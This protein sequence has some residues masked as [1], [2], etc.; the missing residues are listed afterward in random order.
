M[1]IVFSDA[2]G[3]TWFVTDGLHRRPL[4]AGEPQLLVDLGLL[5]PQRDAWGNIRPKWISGAHLAR[6]PL[7]K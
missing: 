2:T 7:A 4:A 1:Q 6:I 5:T 3:D